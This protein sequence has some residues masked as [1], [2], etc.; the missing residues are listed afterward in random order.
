[1]RDFDQLTSVI[2]SFFY[3][4]EDLLLF[5]NIQGGCS[6][7][8]IYTCSVYKFQEKGVGRKPENKHKKKLTLVASVPKRGLYSVV[9][10]ENDFRVRG[11]RCQHYFAKR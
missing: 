7:Y 6:S 2:W 4:V 5:F 11:L 9:N 3:E 8:L 10:L 1:V